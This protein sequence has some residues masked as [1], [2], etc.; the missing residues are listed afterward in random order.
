LTI[1]EGEGGAGELPGSAQALMVAEL[2]SSSNEFAAANRRLSPLTSVWLSL[3]LKK[4][5][6]KFE[7]IKADKFRL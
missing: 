2:A 4:R 1:Q 7:F 6:V 5:G 3:I